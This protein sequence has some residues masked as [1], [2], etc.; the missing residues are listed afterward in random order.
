[1]V[2]TRAGTKVNSR[3]HVMDKL[4]NLISGL[5]RASIDTGGI[6]RDTY[7]ARFSWGTL[8]P[9][10]RTAAGSLNE[11][12]PKAI[13][14]KIEKSLCIRVENLLFITIGNGGLID[15][16]HSFFVFLKRI[17]N[18][19]TNLIGTKCHHGAKKGGLEEHTAGSNEKVVFNI[20]ARLMCDIRL[21]L[22]LLKE[23]EINSI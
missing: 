13:F 6:E 2:R 8:S 15:E 4:V 19:K 14:L 3:M 16:C 23:L 11:R 9:F 12:K 18:G 10:P 20:V 21:W 7:D 5:F 22:P 17:V 1:M